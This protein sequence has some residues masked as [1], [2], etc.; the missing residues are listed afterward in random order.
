MSTPWFKST[1]SSIIEEGDKIMDRHSRDEIA[2]VAYELYVQGGCLQ[3]RDLEYW[4]EAE[5]I[6]ARGHA[7]APPA[8][9]TRGQGNGKKP[10]GKGAARMPSKSP[11][12]S[13]KAR[14]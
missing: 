4:C 2:R 13:A 1:G 12:K 9:E 10:K 8:A 6:V 5:R 11:R 14:A 3:G 7:A